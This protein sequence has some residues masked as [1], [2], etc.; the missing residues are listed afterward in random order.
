MFKTFPQCKL[1]LEFPEILSQSHICYHWLSV[2][3]ISKMMHCGIL[4]DVPLI[5]S[6]VFIQICPL[7]EKFTVWSVICR[8]D[9]FTTRKNY[10]DIQSS[11]IHV[12]FIQTLVAA[13]IADELWCLKLSFFS[14]NTVLTLMR[15]HLSGYGYKQTCRCL[16]SRWV[17]AQ[18][19]HVN[20]YPT[21]HHFGNPIHTESMI[22]VPRSKYEPTT[23][24]P[25]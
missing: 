21:M 10:W 15:K 5:C 6:C 13:C 14:Y 12:R 19:V 22:S 3:E 1:L 7:R 23:T 25:K 18:N 20:E 2:S 16:I 24:L 17:I 11:E 8:G 4:I 9:V